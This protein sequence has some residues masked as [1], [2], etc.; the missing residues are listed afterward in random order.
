MRTKYF[1]LVDGALAIMSKVDLLDHRPARSPLSPESWP[2]SPEKAA[3]RRRHRRRR[4]TQRS[5]ETLLD[6]D[7]SCTPYDRVPLT[8]EEPPATKPI[9]APQPPP[10]SGSK[11]MG[12]ASRCSI[13]VP[14]GVAITVAERKIAGSNA[15]G[16]EIMMNSEADRGNA[17][18]KDNDDDDD[19]NNCSSNRRSESDGFTSYDASSLPSLAIESSPWTVSHVDEDEDEERC[20]GPRWATKTAAGVLETPVTELIPLEAET[21]HRKQGGHA[22]NGGKPSTPS[23]ATTSAKVSLTAASLGK[24]HDMQDG[25]LADHNSHPQ[26]ELYDVWIPQQYFQGKALTPSKRWRDTEPGESML[27]VKLS[28]VVCVGSKPRRSG[29]GQCK[30]SPLAGSI[31][32]A[33]PSMKRCQEEM[34]VVEDTVGRGSSPSFQQP[35]PAIVTG[36]LPGEQTVVVSRGRR[37]SSTVSC[38]KNGGVSELE[39]ANGDGHGSKSTTLIVDNPLLHP[40]GIMGAR[41][42]E[43]ERKEEQEGSIDRWQEEDEDDEYFD[44]AKTFSWRAAAEVAA[45]GAAAQMGERLQIVRQGCGNEEFLVSIARRVV[46]SCSVRLVAADANHRARPYQHVLL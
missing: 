1:G 28:E 3:E 24:E 15:W 44:Y 30:A 38:V 39:A 33:P 37:V 13:G 25:C 8:A 35:S 11:I 32:T 18:D 17:D 21:H 7:P 34:F 23:R 19:V 2:L 9:E 5:L 12:G 45:E 6:G 14:G 16:S 41:S 40:D 27:A 26:P 10:W 46:R 42:E 43:E 36:N 29:P 20:D 31:P 4:R 22:Q